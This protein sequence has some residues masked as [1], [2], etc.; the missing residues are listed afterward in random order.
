MNHQGQYLGR[1]QDFVFDQ[2]G[3]V[4]FAVIGFWNWNWRTIGGNSV[5]VPFNALTYEHH[6]KHR[7]VVLDM[8]WEKFQS[9][10][11]FAKT[12]LMDRQRAEE[13]YKY[14]GLQPYWTE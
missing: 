12:D 13:V 2:D 5:A 9:A 3:H 10:P 7:E 1:I 11:R 8:S 6:G 14:F 4:T